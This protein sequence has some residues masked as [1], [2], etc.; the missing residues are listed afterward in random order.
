MKLYDVY[1]HKTEGNI[2]QIQCFANHMNNPGE[3]AVIVF[4]NIEVHNKYEAGFCPSNNGYGTID[5]ILNEYELL[6]SESDLD[7]Y[8]DWNEIV[9]LVENK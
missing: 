1:K 9:A 2:I 6:V 5:E 3:N 4:S 7:K 8:E